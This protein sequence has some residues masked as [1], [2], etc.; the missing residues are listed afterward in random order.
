MLRQ[1]SRQSFWPIPI[2][3][4]FRLMDC[5]WVSILPGSLISSSQVELH[6]GF[7]QQRALIGNF[8]H[9]PFQGPGWFVLAPYKGE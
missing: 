3:I 1:L 8:A 4:S 2:E 5:F 9:D 6:Q 7:T